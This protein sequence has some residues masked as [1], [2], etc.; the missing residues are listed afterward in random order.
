MF[1]GPDITF[2]GGPSYSADRD[3]FVA[4]VSAAGTVLDFCG[5]IG[6]DD[7]ELGSAIA[8]DSAGDVYVAGSTGSDETTFPV[9]V[10]PDLTLDGAGCF[11]AKI[12]HYGI[13]GVSPRVGTPSGGNGVTIYGTHFNRGSEVSFDGIPAVCTYKSSRAI[14]VIAPAHPLGVVDIIVTTDG[15]ST[16]PSGTADDYMYANTFQSEDSRVGRFGGWK[17]SNPG[18]PR[19]VATPIQTRVEHP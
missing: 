6:G 16:N 15:I 8:L 11:V 19:E 3:A 18:R 12:A 1:D 17:T 5:Y 9:L 13:A 14:G 4:K 7:S 10:G 2:A